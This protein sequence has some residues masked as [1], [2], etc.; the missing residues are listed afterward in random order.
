MARPILPTAF[1][2]SMWWRGEEEREGKI[3]PSFL[4]KQCDGEKAKTRK[5][6]VP[7]LLSLL[8]LRQDLTSLGLGLPTV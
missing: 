2:F 1:D 7:F 3:Y 5:C 6:K 4:K 8:A